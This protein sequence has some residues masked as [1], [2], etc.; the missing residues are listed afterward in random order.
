[1]SPGDELDDE[2]VDLDALVD[3]DGARDGVLLLRPSRSA[4]GVSFP[5]LMSSLKTVWS[6]VTCWTWPARMQVDAAVADVRD[7]ALVADDERS[8]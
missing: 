7:E 6:S 2:R 1:M 5:R 3:A 8:R 4:R